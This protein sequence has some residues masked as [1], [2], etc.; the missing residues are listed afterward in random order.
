MRTG[1]SFFLFNK[2]LIALEISVAYSVWSAVVMAALAGIGMTFL[3]ESVS[4]AKILG[5]LS[6]I[7]GTITLS[8]VGVEG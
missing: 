3:G 5:I 2:S 8:M 6:I 4:F 7:A 1:T